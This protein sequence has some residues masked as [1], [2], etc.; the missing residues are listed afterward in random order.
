MHFSHKPCAFVLL[1]NIFA[2]ISQTVTVVDLNGLSRNH[3]NPK[4]L[5]FLQAISKVGQDHYP[6]MCGK[7]FVVNS[8]DDPP[9][10]CMHTL[11]PA[12]QTLTVV[13]AAGT[14]SILATG[15]ALAKRPPAILHCTGVMY[16]CIFSIKYCT[17]GRITV[18]YYIAWCYMLLTL[19]HSRA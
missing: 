18:H 12:C 7:I 15:F 14:F 16:L 4:V 6:E 17:G 19:L 3:L 5:G 11:Y 1:Q 8:G 13:L 10:I 2:H 9:L